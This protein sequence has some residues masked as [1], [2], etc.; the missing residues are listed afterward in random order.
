[1]ATPNQRVVKSN[2]DEAL[3]AGSLI[4]AV[5]WEWIKGLFRRLFGRK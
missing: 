1:M 5:I 4:F 3:D 2:D